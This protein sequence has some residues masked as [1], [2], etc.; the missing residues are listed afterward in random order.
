MWITWTYRFRTRAFLKGLSS[1]LYICQLNSLNRKHKIMYL[2]AVQSQSAP[3][4]GKFK[5]YLTIEFFINKNQPKSGRNIICMEII[6]C[7]NLVI[8]LSIHQIKRQKSFRHI[9][10]PMIKFC[11]V[12]QI[13]ENQW[14]FGNVQIVPNLQFTSQKAPST[15]VESAWLFLV[16]FLSSRCWNPSS[17]I[18]TY[19]LKMKECRKWHFCHYCCIF[20]DKYHSKCCF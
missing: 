5:W 12:F 20:N 19:G 17:V 3:S 1:C 10:K 15:I 18:L 14:F 9:E 13:L 11:D 8:S 16:H 7:F 6:F 4:T 2:P